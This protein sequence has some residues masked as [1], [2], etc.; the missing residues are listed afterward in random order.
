MGRLAK[1]PKTKLYKIKEAQLMDSNVVIPDAS[2]AHARA[3]IHR[4]QGSDHS[5]MANTVCLQGILIRYKHTA[6]ADSSQQTP[7]PWKRL[8][9]TVA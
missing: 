9:E 4:T 2:V 5:S 1:V 3:P 8:L 6:S 7:S